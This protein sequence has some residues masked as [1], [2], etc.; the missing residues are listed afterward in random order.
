[1]YNSFIGREVEYLS[2]DASNWESVEVF[3]YCFSL[4]SELERIISWEWD[5]WGGDE[6]L[7]RGEG[8]KF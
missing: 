2:V 6:G 7:R 4:L 5:G 8:M 3:S 1:M